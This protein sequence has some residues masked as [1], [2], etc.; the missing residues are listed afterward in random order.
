MAIEDHLLIKVSDKTA[1]VLKA[2]LKKHADDSSFGKI[3]LTFPQ[4]LEIC[5]CD[6]YVYLQDIN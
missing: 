5:F 3:K 4:G 1:L 6:K 2:I